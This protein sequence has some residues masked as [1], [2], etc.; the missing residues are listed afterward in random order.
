MSLSMHPALVHV[1]EQVGASVRDICSELGVD[2]SDP[3]VHLAVH[4][5]CLTF[6]QPGVKASIESQVLVEAWREAVAIR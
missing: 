6:L 4:A 5:M 3:Q 2:L 1:T